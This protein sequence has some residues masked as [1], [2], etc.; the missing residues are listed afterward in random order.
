LKAAARNHR[1]WFEAIERALSI[2]EERL[3]PISLPGTGPPPVRLWADRDPVAAKRLARAR[4]DL[5]EFARERS[6]PVENLLAPDILR[7]LVWAPPT[8]PTESAVSEQL[9]ALG[10]RHWQVAIAAPIIVKAFADEA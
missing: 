6:V 1:E 7:R 5:T 2:P 9:R 8:D 10:A 4:S 3:P